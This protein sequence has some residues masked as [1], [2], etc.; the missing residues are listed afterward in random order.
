[1]GGQLKL[2]EETDLQERYLGTHPTERVFY[3]S[4]LIVHHFILPVKLRL[5]YAV[6][7]AFQVGLSRSGRVGALKTFSDLGRALVHGLSHH[8]AA[9]AAIGKSIRSGRITYMSD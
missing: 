5:S 1:M 7:R 2:G 3:E 6:R 4:A 8:S 9:F